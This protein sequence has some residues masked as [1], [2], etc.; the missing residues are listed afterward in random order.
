MEKYRCKKSFSAECYDGD[1]F[2]IPNKYMDVEVGDIYELDE[3]GSAIMGA[4]IHLDASDGSWL[5]I[6]NESLQ[7]LFEE[8]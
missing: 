3:S 8:I 7:E 2:F 6:S 4:E 1:G 5:E